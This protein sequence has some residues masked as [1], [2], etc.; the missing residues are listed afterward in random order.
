MFAANYFS[1]PSVLTRKC[2]D[3]TW[4]HLV[5]PSTA[6]LV[7]TTVYPSGT[8]PDVEQHLRSIVEAAESKY[9]DAT[10]KLSA[11][12]II[13]DLETKSAQERTAKK[14][15]DS[16]EVE[17]ARFDLAMTHIQAWTNAMLDQTKAQG[18]M[19][20]A[21]TALETFQKKHVSEIL[22]TY[23][24]QNRASAMLRQQ[25]VCLYFDNDKAVESMQFETAGEANA[26][27]SSL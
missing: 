24:S 12:K 10:N 5:S 25:S 23:D 17:K 16:F 22:L 7:S 9:R 18:D 15:L 6:K 11:A 19:L 3:L 26:L 8:A 27:Y 1:R 13:M 2:V 4:Q 14:K 21:K 20:G